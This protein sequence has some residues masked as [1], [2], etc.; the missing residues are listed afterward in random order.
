MSGYLEIHWTTQ[1]K[2][3]AV[4][5]VH[6]LLDAGLIG[7]AQILPPIESIY[8]WK[9]AVVTD[10]EVKVLLK[11]LPENFSSICDYICKIGKEDVPE[12]SAF[13]TV[14]CNPEY[15]SWLQELSRNSR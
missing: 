14:A 6:D 7:C 3:D 13:A 1:L 15:L 9:G 4:N 5:I 8:L 10:Q 11:A 2:E 12:V